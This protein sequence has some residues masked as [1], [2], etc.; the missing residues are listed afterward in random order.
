MLLLIALAACT[1][2]TST[3]TAQ[4]D[5]EPHAAASETPAATAVRPTPAIVTLTP[6]GPTPQPADAT[7]TPAPEPD[8]P[9]EEE[10]D[11]MTVVG[12]AAGDVLNVR[13]AAGVENDLAGDLAPGQ[14]GI[15]LAGRSAEVEGYTWQLI[16]A[17]NVQGWVNSFFLAEQVGQVD[18]EAAQTAETLVYALAEGDLQTVAAAVHPDKGVRFS[19]Y[20]Y[21]R[22]DQDLVFS[23]GELAGLGEDSSVYH[24]GTFDGSGRPIDLTFADYL[25]RFVVDVEFDH[26]DVVGMNTAVGEGNTINNLAEA[27]PDAVFVE[28]HLQGIDESYAGMDWRSLRLVLEQEGDAWYLVGVVHDEWTI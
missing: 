17:G 5:A 22:P 8:S 21:V 6:V 12:V 25:A 3:P 28:Y 27:Y 13:S 16:E 4:Q 23:A 7:P 10:A 15:T 2:S 19:P 11:L 9:V 24:W 20:A 26:P 14:Q 18:H 1:P